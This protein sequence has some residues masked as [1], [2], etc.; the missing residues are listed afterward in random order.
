M[1]PFKIISI[2]VCV[3]ILS[4]MLLTACG[5]KKSD[6]TGDEAKTTETTVVLETTAEGGTVEQDSEGNIVTKD[7][8]GKVVSVTDK[9]GNSIDVVEYVTTHQWIEYSNTPD[10]NSSNSS[11]A[12]NGGTSS[13]GKNSSSGTGDKKEDEK[14]ASSDIKDEKTEDSIPVEIATVPDEDDMKVISDNDL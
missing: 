12:A 2:F 10:G 11:S 8:D 14:K 1:K 6:A 9:N 4:V 13:G 3:V 5:E 7:H